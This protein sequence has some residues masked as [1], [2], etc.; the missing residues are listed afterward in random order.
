MK[1]PHVEN[2]IRWSKDKPEG[3]VLT[4]DLTNSSEVGKWRDTYPDRF[5]PMKMASIDELDAIQVQAALDEIR[6]EIMKL[7]DAGRSGS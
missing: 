5:F 2:F 6:A 4:A 7:R 1:R 3:V